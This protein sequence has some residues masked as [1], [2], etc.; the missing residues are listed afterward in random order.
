M[1]GLSEAKNPSKAALLFN[2]YSCRDSSWRWVGCLVSVFGCAMIRSVLGVVKERGA[3]GNQT[4]ERCTKKCSNT[5][6][7]NVPSVTIHDRPNKSVKVKSKPPIQVLRC[8]FFGWHAQCSRG[9]L[10]VLT[11]LLHLHPGNNHGGKCT[12]QCPWVFYYAGI[13]PSGLIFS[14]CK[15][16]IWV[17]GLPC[18]QRCQDP[19]VFCMWKYS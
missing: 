16:S 13:Y 3:K 7:C 15:V 10:S 8:P 5:F 2:V 17:L 4:I 1:D 12:I 18:L 6:K 9:V 19:Y 11:L 14:H